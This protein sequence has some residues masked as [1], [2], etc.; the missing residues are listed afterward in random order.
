MSEQKTNY[1]SQLDEWTERNVIEPLHY[2]I[3]SEGEADEEAITLIK[4]VIREKVLESYRNGQAA[5]PNP[6]KGRVWKK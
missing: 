6:Q 3:A 4:K 2:A 1:M 5:K